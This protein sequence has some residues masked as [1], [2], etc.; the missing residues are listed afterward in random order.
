[1]N[2]SRTTYNAQ[3]ARLHLPPGE[4]RNHAWPLYGRFVLLVTLS[5]L[6]GIVNSGAKLLLPQLA[7]LPSPDATPH[8]APCSGSYMTSKDL[9]LKAEQ[10]QKDNPD[11]KASAAPAFEILELSSAEVWCSEAAAHDGPLNALLAC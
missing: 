1:M 5:S 6:A 7:F 3:G 8:A 11:F 9:S 4:K 2:A 10:D